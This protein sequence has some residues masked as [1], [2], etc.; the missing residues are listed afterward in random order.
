[1][2]EEREITMIEMEIDLDEK[3]HAKVLEYAKENI[4]NDE[5]ALI[6]WAVNVMLSEIVETDGE[7]LKQKEKENGESNS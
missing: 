5:K 7:C 3:T 4:L 2:C 6:N 1:M